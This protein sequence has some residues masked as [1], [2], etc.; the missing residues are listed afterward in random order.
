MVKVEA[1]I[2]NK[3]GIHCR[4]SAVISKAIEGYKGTISISSEEE[5]IELNTIFSLLS[6][7]LKPGDTITIKVEGLEETLAAKKL[8]EL[9]EYEY[10]FPPRAEDNGFEPDLLAARFKLPAT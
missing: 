6:L 2:K 8:I 3:H 10:D 7:G 9:F 5:T 4:P 1:T